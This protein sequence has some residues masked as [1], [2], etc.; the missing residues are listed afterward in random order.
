MRA[1]VVLRTLRGWRGA[2]PSMGKPRDD[3]RVALG[4]FWS[5]FL[6]RQSSLGIVTSAKGE[7][8]CAT[9][10]VGGLDPGFTALTTR[11]NLNSSI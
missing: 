6:R 1:D 5:E 7:N 8:C 9:G 10:V 3:L 4:I 11:I 2:V